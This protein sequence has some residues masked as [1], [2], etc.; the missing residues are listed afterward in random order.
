MAFPPQFGRLD[1]SYGDVLLNKGGGKFADGSIRW[2]PGL[3]LRGEVRD[4]KVINGKNKR[5]VLVAL[6]DQYP[7][8]V[9]TA[10]NRRASRDL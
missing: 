4:I 7:R 9:S 2:N 1:A 5:Y 3:N 8:F 10:K 6:N